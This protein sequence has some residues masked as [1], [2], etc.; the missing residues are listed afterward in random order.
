MKLIDEA[1]YA[2][3][4]RQLTEMEAGLSDKDRAGALYWKGV[5]FGRLGRFDDT[6]ACVDDALRSVEP[7]SA[8]GICLQL[9]QAYCFK[10]GEAPE[11]EIAAIRS[12]LSRYAKQFSTPDFF[13]QYL[14]AKTALG[15]RLLRAGQ[16]S[17]GIAE[18][19]QV[20]LTEPR[21]A[22]RYSAR[23]WLHDA[24]YKVGDLD[25][26]KEYL[27]DALK[28]AESA[29]KAQLPADHPALVR[30]ELALIAYKQDRL[31][32]A[33]RE[34]ALACAAAQNPKTLRVISKLSKLLHSH[35]SEPPSD[36]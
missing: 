30:Y 6:M 2:D 3:A 34:L 13:W 20:V 36:S 18:L 1:Q 11:A 9:Q 16:Y 27:E 32:D 22:A 15:K 23:V 33:E 25:K 14:D 26:A 7:D 12:V 24:Y 10:R 21:P 28:D 5:C 8:L 17:E 35:K 19:Q 4:A 29:P 31:A